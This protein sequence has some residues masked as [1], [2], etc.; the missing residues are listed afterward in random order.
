MNVNVSNIQVTLDEII[1]KNN[2]N[3]QVPVDAIVQVPIGLAAN[4]CGT[5]VALLGQAGTNAAPCTATAENTNRGEAE[6]I[7]RAIQRQQHSTVNCWQP[8]T[9]VRGCSFSAAPIP[10]AT[11]SALMPA[12]GWKADVTWLGVTLR[13][14]PLEANPR[15]P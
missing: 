10:W 15:R 2:L 6:A 14:E 7:A 13:S 1:S 5:T 3:V 9:W 4:V 11:A 12:T 8:S